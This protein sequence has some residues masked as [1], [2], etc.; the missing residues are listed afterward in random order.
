MKAWL[1]ARLLGQAPRAMAVLR[2]VRPVLKIGSTVIVTR[3]DDVLEVFRRDDVFDTPYKAQIDVLTGGEPFFLGMRAGPDYDAGVKAMRTVMHAGDLARLGER[4]ETLAATA[5]AAHEGG[6]D[7]VDDLA[8]RVTF[9]LYA[10]YLGIPR[11]AVGRIEVWATRLFEFQFAGSPDDHALRAEVDAIAPAFRAHIDSEITRRKS[12]G[13]NGADDVMARCLAL[14]AEGETQF[15]DTFIRTHLLCMMVG[16]PPQP[17]MVIP[18]AMEQLLRRPTALSAAVAAARA[19]DD[20]RLWRIVREALRFDPLAPALPRVATA[21]L[22]IACGTSRETPL[23]AG[24][25]VFAAFASAMRDPRRLPS[26]ETFD[27]DRLDHEYIHFGHGLH[28]C[29]GRMM[30]EATLH[31]ILKPLLKQPRLRRASGPSGRLSKNG[32][33]ADRLTVRYGP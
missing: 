22:T 30:N 23:A 5:V 6:L 1:A 9:E 25:K 3:Y 17:P 27:P 32:V 19:D 28:E 7:V 16:G 24:T 2:R 18:H 14:Q 13:S 4:A 20:E 31:R 29:F 8:R 21:D 33:F 11:P 26:P 15:T 12:A 10:D